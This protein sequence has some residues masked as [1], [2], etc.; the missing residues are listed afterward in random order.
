MCY[1]QKVRK[2]NSLM[3]ED[4]GGGNV[5]GNIK[6]KNSCIG[7]TPQQELDFNWFFLQQNTRN[8]VLPRIHWFE[9]NQGTSWIIFLSFHPSQQTEQ[10]H[11]TCRGVT[12]HAHWS[13]CTRAIPILPNHSLFIPISTRLLHEHFKRSNVVC[14]PKRALTKQENSDPSQFCNFWF[15]ILILNIL[16]HDGRITEGVWTRSQRVCSRPGLFPVLSL[17][18]KFWKCEY[19]KFTSSPFSVLWRFC[20]QDVL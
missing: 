13:T 8:Y 6:L 19:H 3:G 12:T 4:G 17:Q 7:G 16:G 9:C 5:S 10:C 20:V 14:I 1:K 11:V 18:R 15:S 2:E